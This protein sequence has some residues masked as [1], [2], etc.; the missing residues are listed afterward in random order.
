MSEIYILGN[1]PPPGGR[2]GNE[3]NEKVGKISSYIIADL[4]VFTNKYKY[5]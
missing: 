2:G 4:S 3:K 5:T 1:E